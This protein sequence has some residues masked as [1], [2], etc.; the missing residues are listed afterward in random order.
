MYLFPDKESKISSLVELL[1]LLTL[2]QEGKLRGVDIINKLAQQF[3]NWKP[4]SGTIYPII[5][6][7]LTKKKFVSVEG[8]YYQLTKLGEDVLVEGLKSLFET[9]IFI[10]N[11][12]NYSR[13]LMNEIDI[14]KSEELWFVNHMPHL[15]KLIEGLPMV[16][17]QLSEKISSEILLRLTKLQD[18]LSDS[19]QAIE[20]Q[21]KAIKEEE[22]I[23]RVKIK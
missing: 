8:K 20:K 13:V 10:D 1:I 9:V 15:K 12:F 17:S 7:R 23:V 18:I 14:L 3:Q 6:N 5:K 4:Q 2:K 16:R 22:K 19:L 11:V 21:I